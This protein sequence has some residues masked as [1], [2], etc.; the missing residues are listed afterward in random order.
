MRLFSDQLRTF[1]NPLHASDE[2]IVDFNDDLRA[3]RLLEAYSF[4]IFPWPHPDLPTLWFCP[5]QRGILEFREF[6]ISK[7]LKKFCRQAPFRVTFDRA[8][9]Q[10][11]AACASLPRPG[12]SGTWITD[13]LLKAYREFHRAGYVHSLE[14]WEGENLV[15]G[16]YGVYVAGLFSGESMFYLRPNASKFGLVKL[17]EF[18]QS[19]GLEW[20]DIQMVT[21]LLKSLGGKYISRADFLAR[22]ERGKANARQIE[23][24]LPN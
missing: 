3:E 20:I 4:G 10:V 18:L 6:H 11:L 24:V 19:N 13:K 17:I 15:G 5:P 21:P 16:L 23:F 9:D 1:P 14:V 2:G 7:S 22:L 8:F 12:Q